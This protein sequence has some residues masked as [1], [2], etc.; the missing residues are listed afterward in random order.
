MRSSVP[1]LGLVLLAGAQSALADKGPIDCAKKSLAAA[2]EDADKKD[3]ILFTGVC[4]GSGGDYHR[5]AH[6]QG[7]RHGNY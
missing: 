1:V 7:R 6:A 5:R 4:V 3:T 2:V